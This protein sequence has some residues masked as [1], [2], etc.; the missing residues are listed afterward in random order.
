ME[1]K[2]MSAV[3][4]E[5]AELKDRLKA[6]WSAGDY[7]VVAQ[8]LKASAEEFLS[9]V[10]IEPG[11]RV[12]DVACGTGQMA[13]P[14]HNAG[15]KVVGIDIAPNLIDQARARAVSEQSDIQFDVGDAESMPYQDAEFDLVIS[16]IGA[17]FA[18]RPELAASELI[19]VC[20]P[21]GR[22]VMG[23]WTPEGFIGKMFKIVSKYAPPSP[24]MESPL[25]W[26]Q[27]DVVRERFN[28]DIADLK[29]TKRMYPFYYPF[30]ATE[31]VDLFKEYFG[32]INRAFAVLDD[33]GQKA[34]RE[35]LEQL[36]ETN[37][38]ANNGEIA[39]DAEILEVV[40][41]RK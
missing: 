18:P 10:P 20:K 23:N 17:M 11:S 2:I 25:K 41:T 8:N 15:A 39:L 34:L 3:P 16:L 32:P 27:T 38:T 31:V 14:A 4:I 28:S 24:L 13:F 22:I 19:R 6:T 12:L 33:R 36:W 7:G 26:G 1:D 21:G 35:E 37:N 9:R 5:I 30:S 29:I 40:A